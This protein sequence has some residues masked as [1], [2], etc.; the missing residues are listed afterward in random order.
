MEPIRLATKEEIEAIREQADLTPGS[1]VWRMGEIT[2]VVRPVMELDPVFYGEAGEQ[3]KLLFVWGVENMLRATGAPAY[4][5]NVP[6]KEEFDRYRTIVKKWGAEQTSPEPEYR[7][8]KE[9]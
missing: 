9:L 2:G 8:K 5:F 6:A 3:K 4:Y 1:T 7:F